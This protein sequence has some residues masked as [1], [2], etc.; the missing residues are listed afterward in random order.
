LRVPRNPRG[1]HGRMADRSLVELVRELA[2]GCDDQTIAAVLNRLGFTTGQGNGWRMARVNSFRHTHGIE[3]GDGH[4]GCVTLQGAARR[5]RVSDTVVE[6]LIRQR[7]LPARQV[8]Q[9]APWVIEERDLELPAVQAA[10]Q[11]AQ[12]GKRIPSALASHP[13]L[14]IK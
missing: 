5:L 14:S 6:R 10:V 7:V 3:L 1:M 13:E 4:P 2:Q 11:A 8:V 9:Y 12:Q